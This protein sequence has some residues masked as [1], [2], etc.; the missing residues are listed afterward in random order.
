MN[1]FDTISPTNFIA[2]INQR[3]R[4]SDWLKQLSTSSRREQMQEIKATF[5]KYNEYKKTKKRKQEHK[6]Q[7]QPGKAFFNERQ[8]LV[9]YLSN[10]SLLALECY[11]DDN[12][13]FASTKIADAFAVFPS[14][15]ALFKTISIVFGYDQ[16]LYSCIVQQAIK[17]NKFRQS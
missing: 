6:R 14:A 13:Y 1:S 7:E 11:V 5:K 9:E 16:H 4:N 12:E 17:V 15:L 3:T 2:E 8:S 10:F